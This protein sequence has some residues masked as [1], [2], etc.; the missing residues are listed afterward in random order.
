MKN[1]SPTNRLKEY[2]ELL[3]RREES[4]QAVDFFCDNY[5]FSKK[6][7]TKISLK[8]TLEGKGSLPY[9]TEVLRVKKEL[10]IDGIRYENR[11]MDQV[12][13]KLNGLIQFFTRNETY[14]G[15]E[16]EYEL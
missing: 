4:S 3:Q 8:E 11:Q 15:D 9:R 2:N 5:Q 14:D 10:L 6:L 12:E 16:E 7:I 1:V 13:S